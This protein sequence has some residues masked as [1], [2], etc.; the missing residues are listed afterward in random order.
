MI[1][2]VKQ[3]KWLAAYWTKYGINQIQVM[4]FSEWTMWELHRIEI[5]SRLGQIQDK[6]NGNSSAVD[7]MYW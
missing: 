1:L 6:E 4:K 7:V 3:I 2:V 5:G